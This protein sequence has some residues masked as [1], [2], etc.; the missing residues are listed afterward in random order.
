MGMG[1][2]EVPKD[3]KRKR[4]IQFIFSIFTLL[5]VFFTL[6][7]NTL[8]SLT[9]PKVRTEQLT[10]GSLEHTLEGG[11]VLQPI[12]EAKLLNPAGWKITTVL[13]KEGDHVE[14][15]QK[16]ITYDSKSAE[17]ELQDEQTQLKKQKIEL[18]T[19]QDQLILSTRDG[20]EIAIR[21]ARRDMEVHNLDLV[22]QE[23]K[24]NELSDRLANQK[25][26]SA[27]FDGVITKINAVE[28]LSS[29]GEPDVLITNNSRGYRFD[30][31]V[32][33]SLLSSIGIATD[34]K[35]QVEVQALSDQQTKIIDGTVAEIVD[36]E[37]RTENS[38]SNGVNNTVT[39]AQ[40]ILRVKVM[41]A[42]LKGGEQALVKLSK[43]SNQKGLLISSEAIHQ[44]REGK[45][46]YKIEGQKG[47][48]GNVFVARKV[49]IHFSET[50]DKETMIQSE[51]V[52][53]KDLIILESSEPLQDGNRV[54]LQ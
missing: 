49:P 48:L 22:V 25:E 7:S 31:M 40:K 21:N 38:S 30:F 11:G 8:E 47:A 37:S 44:D 16:L 4:T 42:D 41:D 14:K 35:I 36:A 33:R 46:I 39:I 43:R 15:G 18:L 19:I 34:E 32:D 52:S 45:F 26:I 2:Q 13:V 24:I 51:F 5:L 54:R 3:H 1:L 50:N 6:F 20:D 9:L 53:E 12:V 17:R 23:R 27:P 28:G 29:M 10:I